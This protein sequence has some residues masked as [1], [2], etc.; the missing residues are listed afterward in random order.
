MGSEDIN[1][2]KEAFFN[3]WNLVF[4]ITAMVM[5]FL[6]SG[7]SEVL[8]NLILIV[9]AASELLYLGIVPNNERFRRIVRSRRLA[10]RHKPPSQKEIYRRLTRSSQRRYARLRNIEQSIRANYSKLSYASQGLLE[11]HL[12]KISG[13]LDSYLQLLYQK[14]RYRSHSDSATESEVRRSL[15]ALRE[16]LEDEPDRVRSIKKRR[17]RILE[18]RLES[19]Q[20]SHE[21]LKVIEAQLDTISDVIKYIH[22]QSWTLS[23]PEEITLQLDSLLDEVEE[24]QSSVLE[25]EEVFNS[26]YDLLEDSDLYDVDLSESDEERSSEPRRSRTA[27]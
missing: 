18:Q 12:K 15:D 14:E 11:S 16:D 21:N 26:S 3:T 7:A 27:S 17:L 20:Q 6:A 8:L 4:L 23:N 10:E 19:F 1:Y 24:T 22:E 9:A 13:L 5:A 2:T 25:V